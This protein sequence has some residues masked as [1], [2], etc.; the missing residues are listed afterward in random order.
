MSEYPSTFAK[1]LHDAAEHA[2]LRS[3]HASDCHTIA[4]R[5]T[6]DNALLS[7]PRQLSERGLG[8]DE[9]V[10]LLN[11]R[12]VSALAPGQAGPRYY[13]FVTGGVAPAAQ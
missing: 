4:S 9:T 3:Q 13:G 8:F 5:S 7:L 11:E 12:V 10:R 1:A 6:L 2:V